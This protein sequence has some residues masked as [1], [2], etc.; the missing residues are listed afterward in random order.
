MKTNN[1]REII[2]TDKGHY[3]VSKK[4]NEPK[5]HEWIKEK[6]EDAKMAIYNKEDDSFIF[7]GNPFHYEANQYLVVSDIVLRDTEVVPY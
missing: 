5:D 1:E 7:I 6:H 4:G 3:W 2:L